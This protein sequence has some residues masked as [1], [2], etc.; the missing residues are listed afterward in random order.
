MQTKTYPVSLI[1]YTPIQLR[2]LL[3]AAKKQD[4]KAIE[5]LCQA[6][7]PL[8]KK[9]A[10]KDYIYS[11]LK[12]DA[13]NIAWEVFLQLI[14]NYK[15]Q[16]YRLFPGLAQ[17]Y[18]HFELLHACQAEEKINNNQQMLTEVDFFVNDVDTVLQNTA[19]VNALA[20]LTAKQKAVIKAV[21]F[22]GFTLDEYRRQQKVS[23][24]TVY[25]HYQK[26][27]TNLKTLLEFQ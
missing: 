19:L 7:E 6:F 24:K 18:I 1:R 13:V 16:K 4:D 23:F 27:L 21:F 8:I 17:K 22:Q 11:V 9:E 26:A 25:L 15:G 10:H 12:E 14:V 5:A 3:G 2:N 20:K